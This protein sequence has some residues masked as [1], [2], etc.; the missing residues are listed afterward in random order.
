MNPKRMQLLR[1]PVE[2]LSSE[3]SLLP[4]T[5][6]PL[7]PHSS[8]IPELWLP[9]A[10]WKNPSGTAEKTL[11]AQE[12]NELQLKRNSG[13]HSNDSVADQTEA[14]TSLKQGIRKLPTFHTKVAQI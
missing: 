11:T 6:I 9:K 8:H 14:S 4:Q 3:Q 2:V 13:T 12:E 5:H 10:P 7:P 1:K